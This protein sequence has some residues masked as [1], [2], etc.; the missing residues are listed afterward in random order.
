MGIVERKN[1]EREERRKQILEIT[2]ALILERGID[3]MTMADIAEKAELSKATL[4]LSFPS[5]EAILGEIFQEAG[6][7]FIDYVESRMPADISGID[8][9]RT[10][11]MSY[12]EVFGK[13]SDI[14]IMF[15]IKNYI[16]PDFPLIIDDSPEAAGKAQIRMYRLI[17]E[18]AKRG[19]AD[20]TFD[21]SIDPE[22]VS[23]TILL[24]SGGIIDNVARLP[25]AKRDGKLILAEMKSAFEILL[26]G[27]ASERC[28]RSRLVL[29]INQ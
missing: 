29:A 27:L 24:I 13:S 3:A 25:A 23:R 22:K 16:A 20:G 15:G 8:A 18:V 6:S 14:F 10:I 19:V 1:R 17:A 11:W 7:Y 5:K 28:D 2:R 12:I 9:I 4:Y 21:A 26:R